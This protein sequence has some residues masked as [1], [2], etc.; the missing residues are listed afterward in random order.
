MI[1]NSFLTNEPLKLLANRSSV[2]FCAVGGL[3]YPLFLGLEQMP[4]P[5]PRALSA[6][7]LPCLPKCLL[8][9]LTS[10]QCISQIGGMGWNGNLLFDYLISTFVRV[11]QRETLVFLN[12]FFLLLKSH[13]LPKIVQSVKSWGS[14][15]QARTV[16]MLLLFLTDR[17]ISSQ[18]I[19]R[20][21]RGPLLSPSPCAFP[22][23]GW[24]M[25]G[26]AL[27]PDGC[28]SEFFGGSI[29]HFSCFEKLV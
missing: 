22:C 4:L 28:W 24:F 13:V 27:S 11:T 17:L 6:W 2:P 25:V 23:L 10:S 14:F 21:E 26:M 15:L 1:F 5:L 8:S 16:V 7:R 9:L 29:W 20:Q 19:H 3:E 12:F 18:V